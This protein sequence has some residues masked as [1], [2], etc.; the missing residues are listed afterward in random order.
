MTRQMH[1]AAFIQGVG[2]A[3]GVWKSPRTD[4]A[5]AMT[6]N[7]WVE[8][9]QIAEA[10][11]FDAFFL[12]DAL[13]IGDQIA[14][15]STE[16]PDPVVVLGALAG[17]TQ[18]IGLIGTSSTT[19]NEPF[20][21]ARQFATLDHLTNGRAGWNIVTTAI[22]AAA[23][24]FG[25]DPLPAHQDRYERA[26]E[27][28]QV[29]VGLWECWQEDAIVADVASGTYG[30]LSR[31]RPLDHVGKFFQ[32]KGPL[33]VRRSPQGRLA[34][35]QAGSSGPGMRLGARWAD[36]TFTTQF[37]IES[38]R[39]F[40]RE[41]RSLATS[42]G[43][44]SN[45]LKVLPGIMPIVGATTAEAREL[46]NEFASYVDI[47]KI[48]AFLS[49]HLG[50]VDLSGLDPDEPFPDITDQLPANASVSRPRLYIQTALR[51]KLTVRQLAQRMAMS[52]GHRPVIGTADE[53]A[54]D[55]ITW[56]DAEAADGFVVI[57]A[58]LP[59]GLRDFAEHVVPRLQDRGYFR[60]KYSGSTLREHLAS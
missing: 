1:F 14:A 53:V 38:S 31:I 37:D 3:Q 19:Y 21:V 56:F 39:A 41:T 58:D 46:A 32:V 10:A 7:H 13:T 36:L 27:F 23:G 54:Q 12:A 48:H 50:G 28:V 15:D 35:S 55:L 4:A 18:R 33:P 20:T 47:D 45:A 60:R 9:A 5:A 51:E 16:R 26:E 30:D 49:H 40:V 29:V 42:F 59:Q 43:R 8:V 52:L 57:A 34:L 6:L 44:P 22:Q 25:S 17:F 2:A 11:C 24:N